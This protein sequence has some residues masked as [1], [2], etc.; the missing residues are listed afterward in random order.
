M[1][2][3]GSDPM[4]GW[5]SRLGGLSEVVLYSVSTK[6]PG[7]RNQIGI[8]T[9]SR[10]GYPGKKKYLFRSCSVMPCFFGLFFAQSVC[11]IRKIETHQYFRERLTMKKIVIAALL[12]AVSGAALATEVPGG[13]KMVFEGASATV[14][15]GASV[16]ITGE[17]GAPLAAGT[18][19]VNTNGSFTTSAP[20]KFEIRDVNA[21]GVVGKVSASTNLQMKYSMIE[22][23]AGPTAGTI[24]NP[25]VTVTLTNGGPI[26]TTAS[27]VTA[28]NGL[29]VSKG[30]AIE[31]YVA[32][33]TVKTTVSVLVTSAPAAEA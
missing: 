21:E 6:R 23:V 14:T 32:G 17:G 24:S 8:L 1:A 27:A 28:I 26:T 33:E 3:P 11:N 19:T 4:R 5:L 15:S 29:S 25:D 30:T 12:S 13:A 16:A 22:L 2:L 18:L 7:D 20:V 9:F 10:T 31:N